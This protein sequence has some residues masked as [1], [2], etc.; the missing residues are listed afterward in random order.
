M[1]G[2]TKNL[3]WQT[4]R[5][6]LTALFLLSCA[7]CVNDS[8]HRAIIENPAATPEEIAAWRKKH[9]FVAAS[10][11]EIAQSKRMETPFKNNRAMSPGGKLRVVFRAGELVGNPVLGAASTTSVYQLVDGSGRVL[12][13]APSR[14]TKRTPSE[15]IEDIQLAWFSEDGAKVLIYEYLRCGNGPEPHVV[16]F[17]KDP[18][19]QNEWRVRYP[20]LGDTLNMPYWE[21]DHAECR[22]LLGD[23]ILI[24]NT[25]SGVSKIHLQSLKDNYP[26]P[27][28]V[29]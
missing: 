24:R 12:F 19:V 10:E 14:I 8:P 2:V 11:V 3:H 22:G 6:L 20:D 5:N 26:F 28:S 18:E 13:S 1:Q 4:T 21:G 25:C 7:S 23:E 17:Y 29:G 27:F 16:L 15:E 9:G